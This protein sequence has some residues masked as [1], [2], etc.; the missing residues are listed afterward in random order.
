M[1]ED[2][3][4]ASSG[5]ALMILFPGVLIYAI[6]ALIVRKKAIVEA[7]LCP[8]HRSARS[9]WIL[10]TWLTGVGSFVA[11]IGGIVISASL[12]NHEEFIVFGLL[13]FV[14]LLIVAIVVGNRARC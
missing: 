2:V 10:L 13:A 11:L 8:E 14:V 9:R 7:S 6:V 1:A 4:L 5:L 12:R 3:V